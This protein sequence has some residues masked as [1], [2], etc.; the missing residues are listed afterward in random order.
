MSKRLKSFLMSLLVGVLLCAMVIFINRDQGYGLLRQL[1][2]GCFVAAVLLLGAGVLRYVT[3]QGAFD[4]LGYG[5]QSVFHLHVPGASIGNARDQE[6]ME[7]YRER[8]AKKELIRVVRGVDGTVS[9]DF[10]GKAPGR[11]AY[12]CPDPECLKKAIR[13]KALSRSL[14]TEI[15]QEVYDRLEKEMEQNG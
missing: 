4:V 6:T 9:L 12:L 13:S 8:K 5:L 10:S 1:C 14:E 2:D 15:P 11:G 7:T 3:N